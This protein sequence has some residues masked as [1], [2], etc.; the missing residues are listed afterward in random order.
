MED[1]AAAVHAMSAFSSDYSTTDASSPA[2]IARM[3]VYRAGFLLQI[4]WYIWTRAN[5]GQPLRRVEKRVGRLGLRFDWQQR[6]GMSRIPFGFVVRL[7]DDF[8]LLHDKNIAAV[9]AYLFCYNSTAFTY[10]ISTWLFKGE[11]LVRRLFTR[12]YLT[13]ILGWCKKVE[14]LCVKIK[15]APRPAIRILRENGMDVEEDHNIYAHQVLCVTVHS[16]QKYIIDLTSAQYGWYDPV[17][18]YEQYMEERVDFQIKPPSS[19]GTSRLSKLKSSMKADR[20]EISSS[21]MWAVERHT[22]HIYDEV[23]HALEYWFIQTFGHSTALLGLPEAGYRQ[24]RLKV[25]EEAREQINRT[26]NR[27]DGS[28]RHTV[29]EAAEEYRDGGLLSKVFGPEYKATLKRTRRRT[30]A[31]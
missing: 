17:V 18:P 11:F 16:G 31:W 7:P 13:F 22:F 24:Q 27:L 10:R 3:F 23:D 29:Q 19:H 21:L 30:T 4:I 25:L 15:G 8:L 20:K 1:L 28:W 12:Q 9:L 2:E 26:I 5:Y 6:Q 14:E